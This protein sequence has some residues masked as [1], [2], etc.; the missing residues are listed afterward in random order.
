MKLLI[1]VGLI[2]LAGCATPPGKMTDDD[3]VIRTML[4]RDSPRTV[5]AKFYQGMRFCGPYSGGVAGF[6]VR[7]HGIPECAPEKPDGSETCDVYGGGPYGGRS[8]AVFGRVD[9]L[10][11]PEGT[12]A[13]F[14]AIRTFGVGEKLI[15]SWTMFAEGREREVCG[16]DD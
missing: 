7:T 10:P 5:L 14:R 2:L 6:G 8:D 1:A 16:K 11:A 15:G 4:L 12:K 9:F 3:Y 13:E